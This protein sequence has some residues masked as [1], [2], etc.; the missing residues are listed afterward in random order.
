MKKKICLSA[1]G[2]FVVSLIL[3]INVQADDPYI[4]LIDND[5]CTFDLIDNGEQ[6]DYREIMLNVDDVKAG[7]RIDKILY[8]LNSSDCDDDANWLD[9]SDYADNVKVTA[10]Q[11]HVGSHDMTF[12]IKL[13]KEKSKIKVVFE[14]FEP[15]NITYSKFKLSTDN[16]DE[17]RDIYADGSY[18]LANY[19]DTYSNLVT[20]YL[21]GDIIL[22]KN[23]TDN[24]CILKVTLANA[25][26][27]AYVGRLN[28][29]NENIND[30]MDTYELLELGSMFN[31]LERDDY[32]ADTIYPYEENGNLFI[33]DDGETKSFYLIINKFFND[34]NRSDFV[35]GD[36]KNRILSEEYIGIKY[37]VDRKYFDEADGFLSFTEDN[38]YT[39]NAT[40]F[41]GT[42]E[43]QFKVESAIPLALGA[44]GNSDGMGTMKYPYNKIE[45]RNN[46]KYP[47]D[48]NFKLTINSF[49]EPDYTVPLTLKNGNTNVKNVTLTLSRF[50][51]GGNGGSLLVVDSEGNNCRDPRVNQNCGEGN[52]YAST[53][54]RGLIDTFYTDGS[55]SQVNAFE[56]SNQ[57]QGLTGDAKN[58]I[59]VYNRNEDFSPWATAIFYHDDMVVTTRSFNLSEIVKI[60]GFTEDVIS[61]DIVNGKAKD[62][63]GEF[64]NNYDSNNYNAFGYGSGFEKPIGSIKYFSEG[65]YEGGSIDYPIILASKEELEDN[66]INRIALFLTNGELKSDEDNF[67]EL[68]YGVGEGKIFYVDNRTFDRL[69]G[70]E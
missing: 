54:Y 7:K 12:E 40:I 21:G 32:P 2:L 65:D 17:Y 4:T 45:S 22:P 31:H 23:C 8:C 57:H 25:D 63:N 47:I 50:A 70:D 26:Y 68:T 61:E 34:H 53:S 62:F 29:F 9:T 44:L 35:F 28:Y 27:N 42:P 37:V 55:T 58:N 67:P 10:Y 16:E 43:V 11:N 6:G 41:Y 33:E 51:F 52:Y 49:Y 19:E 60:G 18:D 46:T 15:M 30:G 38:N 48:E 3:I 20:G 59:T 24:G 13:P 69:G 1:I 36:N 39:Q 56:I 66:D 5:N 64:I 14:D